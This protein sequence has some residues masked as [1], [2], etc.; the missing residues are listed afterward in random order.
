M[1]NGYNSINIML[2]AGLAVRKDKEILESLSIINEAKKKLLGGRLGRCYELSYK[3]A[4]SHDGWKLVHGYIRDKIGG[5]GRAIDH[6]W[7]L[8]GDGVF[9]PVLDAN[10][11]EV[12]YKAMFDAEVARI[13]TEEEAMKAAVESGTYGPWHEIDDSKIIHPD[14]KKGAK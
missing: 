14:Y 1:Y 6:A 8:K 7:C 13:Y 3:F 2:K 10:I 5:S 4:T 11:P 9:D 12:V